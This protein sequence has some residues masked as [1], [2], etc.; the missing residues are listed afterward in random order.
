MPPSALTPAGLQ[1]TR[2]ADLQAQAPL[3]PLAPPDS[4][5]ESEARHTLVRRQRRDVVVL[6][7][8]VIAVPSVF[9]LVLAAGLIY[10]Y[11]APRPRKPRPL[12][13]AHASGSESDDSEPTDPP[14]YD[15]RDEKARAPLKRVWYEQ[16]GV[17]PGVVTVFPVSIEGVLSG[18]E[19]AGLSDE[20][21][22]FSDEKVVLDEKAGFSDEKAGADEKHP[23]EK[24]PDNHPNKKHPDDHPDEKHPDTH[25]GHASP[26]TLPPT[27]PASPAYTFRPD[28]PVPTH[29]PPQPPCACDEPTCPGGA[30]AFASGGLRRRGH[31]VAEDEWSD[32]NSSDAD[33]TPPKGPPRSPSCACAVPACPGGE[34]AARRHGQRRR[35]GLPWW[36]RVFA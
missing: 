12:A 24:Y 4:D 7:A 1:P 8:L 15:G 34:I 35:L 17:P 10:H 9:L 20:K 19:K 30:L 27:L 25:P 31:A 5:S 3:T 11:A 32:S 26:L 28:P 33:P 14:P 21:V 29:A 18:D 16:P 6:I 23:D 36:R 13:K 22:G 2:R